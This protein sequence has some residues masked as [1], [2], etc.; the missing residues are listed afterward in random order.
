MPFHLTGTVWK[1]GE[2]GESTLSAIETP[3]IAFFV[4]IFGRGPGTAKL[5]A[6]LPT[7]LR[8][9]ADDGC[10]EGPIPN[11][12]PLIR[13]PA[14]GR[15]RGP[16]GNPGRALVRGVERMVFGMAEDPATDSDV[17]SPMTSAGALVLGGEGCPFFCKDE[18]N[19]AAG[20]G[21]EA[22]AAE[23]ALATARADLCERFLL[24]RV[25]FLS[26]G[27]APEDM[28]LPADGVLAPD[29]P[30]DGDGRIAGEG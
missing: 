18:L 15:R 24:N 5:E 27:E 6:A 1:H 23:R 25:A 13:K 19:N 3:R 26:P 8:G 17:W 11:R 7:A 9:A 22:A 10:R 30:M 2:A 21:D 4:S 20:Y 12:T 29:S 14:V 16:T 28:K